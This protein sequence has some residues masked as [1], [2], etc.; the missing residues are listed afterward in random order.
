MAENNVIVLKKIITW[1]II[2]NVHHPCH[3]SWGFPH[4]YHNIT[5][6]LTVAY[7]TYKQK[8]K[9]KKWWRGRGDLFHHYFD[10]KQNQI[11]NHKQELDMDLMPQRPNSRLC[12]L[13]AISHNATGF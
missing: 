6:S 8:M 13:I 4:T 3:G 7:I 5:T 9:T 10:L 2:I 12:G 11:K 1:N